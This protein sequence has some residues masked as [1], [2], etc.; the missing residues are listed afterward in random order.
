MIGVTQDDGS[1]FAVSVLANKG[2]TEGI[3]RSLFEEVIKNQTWTRNQNSHLHELII[4]QYTDWSNV[5]DPYLLLQRYLDVN[6][7]ASFKA[8]A[9]LSANA[10]VKKQAPTYFYQLERAPKV[11]PGYPTIPWAGIY[12]GADVFYLFSGPFLVAKN[13]TSDTDKKLSKDI[14]TLWTNFAKTGN[15]NNPTLVGTIWPHYTADTEEYLGLSPNLTVRS[16]MRPDKMAFWNELV[17]SIE[18]R[19]APTTTSHIPTTTEQIDDKKGMST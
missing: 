10:F 4:Y 12:H 5:T 7:D 13:L 19:I 11:F 6:T 17:P 8:P 18:E 14:M 2:I 9:I 3:Q 1:V 15:P 16:K